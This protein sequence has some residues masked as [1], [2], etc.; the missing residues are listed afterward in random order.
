MA[1]T[2]P[3]AKRQNANATE[4]PAAEETRPQEEHIVRWCLE[5]FCTALL[6]RVVHL[7]SMDGSP[8]WTVLLGDGR[9]YD[10]WAQELVGGDRIGTK[11]D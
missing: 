8:S 6:L 3:P 7:F 1:S 4:Q 10:A 11:A 9:A 5:V 2:K